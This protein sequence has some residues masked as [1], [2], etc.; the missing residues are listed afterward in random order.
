MEGISPSPLPP[1]LLDYVRNIEPHPFIECRL[2]GAN[3]AAK[4]CF[5]RSEIRYG[6]E[7]IFSV[8]LSYILSPLQSYAFIAP[9]AARMSFTCLLTDACTHV[10]LSSFSFFYGGQGH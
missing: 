10:S 5:I 8:I 2:M 7:C 4:D 6:R 3:H 1:V 9:A